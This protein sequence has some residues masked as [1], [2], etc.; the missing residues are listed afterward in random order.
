VPLARAVSVQR[1]AVGKTTRARYAPRPPVA[2]TLSRVAP[3]AVTR[4]TPAKD[5]G[6]AVRRAVQPRP[7]TGW[8]SPRARATWTRDAAGAA[9]TAMSAATATTPGVLQRINVQIQTPNDRLVFAGQQHSGGSDEM[10]SV[11]P[12]RAARPEAASSVA[13]IAL[14][15]RLP[16]SLP[17]NDHR[18]ADDERHSAK[19]S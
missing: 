4:T 9:V 8:G 11:S 14:L 12:R 7:A 3:V 18:T 13:P 2:R 6:R 17:R 5:A 10:T 16:A 19:P 15:S 1:P